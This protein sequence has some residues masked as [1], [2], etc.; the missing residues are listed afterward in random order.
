VRHAVAPHA[1]GVHG[2]VTAAGQLP[3]PSHAA[4]TVAV[5]LEHPAT[6]HD[7]DD[8]T[9]PAHDVRDIGSP[10]Q[11]AAAHGSLALPVGHAGRAP[12][13]APA[14]GEQVPSEPIR[15]HASHSP[16]HAALQQ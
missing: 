6:L 7:T 15:S 3:W 16:W 2:M 13:G 12:C 8:P 11:S 5:P 1:N 9:Y 14:T 10:L 4:E